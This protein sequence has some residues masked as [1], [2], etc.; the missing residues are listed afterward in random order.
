[1]KSYN[2]LKIN[3]FSSQRKKSSS[4]VKLENEN[5][6]LRVHIKGASEWV[7]GQCNHIL[8]YDAVP[9]ALSDTDKSEYLDKILQMNK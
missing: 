6:K 1:M 7:F 2:Y 4:V 3:P 5:D 8:K 9:K